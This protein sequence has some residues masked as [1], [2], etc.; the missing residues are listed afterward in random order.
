MT[1]AAEL[2]LGRILRLASRP[3]R[4]GDIAEYLRCRSI[5]LDT[6]EDAGF[7]QAT[8]TPNWSRDRGRGAQGD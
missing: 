5:I 6:L 2:A 3:A 4:P 1:K 8:D 7:S